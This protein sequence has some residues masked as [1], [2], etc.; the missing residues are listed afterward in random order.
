MDN[1]RLAI[2]GT[3]QIER[4]LVLGDPNVYFEG[5]GIA[6]RLAKFSSVM[7]LSFLLLPIFI[8][9]FA[10]YLVFVLLF[11]F[12]RL[13]ALLSPFNYLILWFPNLI[14]YRRRPVRQTPVRLFRVRDNEG[15]YE[16]KM[17]GE[18]IQGDVKQGDIVAIFG[19]WRRGSLI[20]KKGFNYRINSAIRVKRSPWP[21][22]MLA[23]ISTY[24]FVGILCYTR[25]R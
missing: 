16:V 22:I 15:E 14:S 21:K 4:G 8:G 24:V 2:R 9:I 20:F 19:R 6:D 3:P 11:S 25:G 7:L 12:L 17:K 1:L 13:G 18:L 10:I 23:I 5:A